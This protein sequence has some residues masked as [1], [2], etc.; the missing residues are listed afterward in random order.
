MPR[1][2]KKTGFRYT[3][4]LDAESNRIL[5]DYQKKHKIKRSQAIQKII[6]ACKK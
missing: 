4:F 3:I 6:A 5:R 1:K 2:P